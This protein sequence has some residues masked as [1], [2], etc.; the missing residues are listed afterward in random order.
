M[1][2]IVYNPNGTINTSNTG[3]VVL[4]DI[5]ETRVTA[6]IDRRLALH[7]GY[8]FNATTS[9]SLELGWQAINYFNVISDQPSV[10]DLIGNGNNNNSG[11]PS[12]HYAETS[13]F[14]LQSPYARV[15]LNIV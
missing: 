5:S 1:D 10:T 15:D 9:L 3:S 4:A 8:D 7:Y 2:V 13:N 12:T 6:E 14:G 11:L